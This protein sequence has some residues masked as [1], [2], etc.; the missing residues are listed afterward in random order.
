MSFI[1]GIKT[2]F[3]DDKKRIKENE[4]TIKSEF[5]FAS[6]FAKKN[7]NDIIILNETGD[8]VREHGTEILFR[9]NPDLEIGRK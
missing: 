2:S 7:K 8:I 9:L 4:Y 1:E 3:G 6:F 5:D